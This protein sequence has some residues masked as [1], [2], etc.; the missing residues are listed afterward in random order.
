MTTLMTSS[1]TAAAVIL[2]L[3]GLDGGGFKLLLA[4]LL[5]GLDQM[6]NGL[7][8]ALNEKDCNNNDAIRSRLLHAYDYVQDLYVIRRVRRFSSCQ[9]NCNCPDIRKHNVS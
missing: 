5:N 6:A 9:A 1:S 4:R 8:V 2:L 3:L 7:L